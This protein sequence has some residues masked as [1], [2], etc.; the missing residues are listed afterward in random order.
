M[1]TINPIILTA[2]FITCSL[3]AFSQIDTKEKTIEMG[4]AVMSPAKDIIANLVNSKDHATLLAAIRAADLVEILQ[5]TGPFTFFAPTNTAFELL[6]AGTIG[7]L[8][9]TENKG[10]LNIILKCHVVAGKFTTADLVKLAEAGNGS[11]SLTTMSGNSLIVSVEGNKLSLIDEKGGIA[12]II[13]KDVNQSNG[14][15]HAI[16]HVLLPKEL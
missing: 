1:K 15:I 11:G 12:Y 2:F 9:K 7:A 14:I 13:V 5:S 8:L 3:N 4:G 16:D 6:P 10:N